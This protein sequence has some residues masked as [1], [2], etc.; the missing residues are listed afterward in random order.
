MTQ[1]M[2]VAKLIQ[3]HDVPDSVHAELRQR[4]RA[5]GMS[6][7]SYLRA[8]LTRITGR[9]P[10]REVLDRIAARPPVEPSFDVTAAIRA[11]RDAGEPGGGLGGAEDDG[12]ELDPN[13]EP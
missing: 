1:L 6:L 4:A 9:P 11:A 5:R 2:T 3:I 8:E 12:G 7:S 10:L 13:V